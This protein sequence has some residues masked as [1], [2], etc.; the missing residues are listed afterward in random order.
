MNSRTLSYL[1]TALIFIFFTAAMVILSRE[2]AQVNF[3]E[4]IHLFRQL[5]TLNFILIIVAGLLAVLSLSLYDYVL[6][7][8]LNVN[9]SLRH[10]LPVSFITN[11]FNNILGLGGLFGAGL[12]IFQ[13]QPK[14][15]DQAPLKRA[16]SLLLLS[17]ISGLS[18]LCYIAY[19]LIDIK[20][21][22]YGNWIVL[23]ACIYA[24]AYIVFSI[25]KPISKDQRL[26][27][28]NFTLVSIIDWIAAILLFY[29]ILHELNIEVPLTAVAGLFI[30]ASLSGTI[31]MIPGGLG[32]FDLVMLT[33]L[34]TLGISEEKGLLALLLYRTV[35]YFFPLLVALLL[36]VFEYKESAKTYIEDNKL[37]SSAA[38]TGSFI[39]AMQKA[40]PYQFS[41]LIVALLT[42]ITSLVYYFN[43][44][45]IVYDAIAERRYTYYAVIIIFHVAASLTLLI[46]ANG[47]MHGTK[48]ATMLS[49]LSTAVLLVTTF[50][51]YGTI[52]SYVWLTTILALLIYKY[53]KTTMI[54][55]SLTPLKIVISATL[56]TLLLAVN[57]WVTIDMLEIY[58]H[59][60]T[61]FD[62]QLLGALMW[63]TV[64]I[65]AVVSALLTYYYSRK[66]NHLLTEE[67]T[68][69]ELKSIIEIEGSYVSHLAFTGDKSFFLNEERDAFLMFHKTKNAL[70]VM[71]DPVGNHEH[72]EQLLMDFYDKA[73]FLGHDVIF[74][75]VQSKYL[76][77]YHGFGN[78]FFK[79]G[80]E[81]LIPLQDFTVS[82][83]KQRA[84]RATLNKLEKEGYT[85]SIVE[86][87]FEDE[88]IEELKRVSDAWLN[89]KQEMRFSV[90]AFTRHYLEQAPIAVI[91]DTENHIVAFSTLMPTHY[92]NTLS[93]DLIRWLPDLDIPAMDALYLNMLLYS[94]EQGYDYFNMG[95]A[96]L[97]NVGQNRYGYARERVAGHVFNHFNN[98]YSF[99]GLRKYKQK[100]N[101][102]W[103]ERFVVYRTYTSL[104]WNL[105]R[106]GLTINKK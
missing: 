86:A 67:V 105:M 11:A 13:Y 103:N 92:N 85:F 100:Y 12:R 65:F 106:I 84:F 58:P 48:R 9:I 16:I 17:T 32:A 26:L 47:V 20:A 87:P 39:R 2:L 60:A 75:Q 93:V 66:Y 35:Y 45:L 22:P 38:M 61:H 51:S 78:H 79:I 30:I 25:I 24:P 41:G 102:E 69:E 104:V 43:H 15:P 54:K 59:K 18:V 77:L 101:P 42:I 83:K 36:S 44:F 23:F 10:L 97:S 52:I 55:R 71:G 40:S 62:D 94:K 6:T 33:G 64:L 81:A 49:I 19:G 8:Q 28:V 63:G 14:S 34:G 3:K 91:K 29:F 80:E 56:I 1:K 68:E 98:L 88:F 46:S 5:P 21:V 73:F 4:T 72:F 31:S 82:G 96:T 37:L 57:H 90:G 50:L 99:Q 95:M 89:G 7:R 76:P 70:I 53:R 27:G 74:Y